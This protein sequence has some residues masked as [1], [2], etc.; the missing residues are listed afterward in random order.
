M[1]RFAAILDLYREQEDDARLQVGRRMR[2]RDDQVRDRDAHL[3]R[4]ADAS[5]DIP[6]EHRSQWLVW[7]QHQMAQIAHRNQAI[8]EA[9]AAV[10]A[11]RA[12]LAE[13]H[14]RCVTFAKLQDIERAT[15]QRRSDR[16]E[17]R[18]SDDRASLAF[19]LA[20]TST[21]ASSRR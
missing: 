5:R 14:R 8:A 21:S 19:I 18:A 9:D 2:D 3:A 1:T 10:E 4:I 11:A 17:Q 16:R 6:L 13:A 12:A 7:H 15:Q 20:S